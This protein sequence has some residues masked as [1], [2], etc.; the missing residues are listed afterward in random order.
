MKE[1]DLLLSEQIDY[2]AA[3][4]PEYD[5]WFFRRGR[6]DQGEDHKNRWEAE[7]KQVSEA[8]KGAFRGGDVLELA[9][10]TGLWTQLLAPLCN[11]VTAV[12]A[13]PE[14]INLCRE[15]VQARNVDYIVADH[16]CPA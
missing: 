4:A 12:D 5:E 11:R 7:I 1:L 8:M 14:T 13:S 15:R 9:C 2:Y 6:Y 3:R 16:Y 10:G